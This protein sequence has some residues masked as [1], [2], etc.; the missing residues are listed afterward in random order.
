VAKVRKANPQFVS[1][2]E[3]FLKQ[4]ADTKASKP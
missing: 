4:E 2:T 3:E 1:E